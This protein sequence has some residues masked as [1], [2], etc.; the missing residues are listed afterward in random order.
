[1]TEDKRQMQIALQTELTQGLSEAEA[2]ARSERYGENRLSE[3]KKK[4]LVRRFFEQF[5]DMMIL[6]LLVAAAVSF[7]LAFADGG[8]DLIELLEPVLILG[9]VIADA[10]LGVIQ[11]SKAEKALEALKKLSAPTARVLRE[12]KVRVIPASLLVPG[13]VVLLEAGDFVPAD[14]RLAESHSLKCEESALTGESVAAEK[15]AAAEVPENAPVAE[16][17]NEVFAGTYVTYG[18]GKA[19]VTRTGMATETGKIAA[20]LSGEKQEATPLQKK[21]GKLGKY[22]GVAALA[23][24]AVIFVMGMISGQEPMELFMTAVSLAVAAIP[25]GL[26]AVVTVVLAVGVQRMAKKNAV[27]RR[28]PAVETLGSA[29]VICS[30][31]TGTLTQ[32]RMTLVRAYADG[33]AEEV[34][35]AHNGEQVRRLLLLGTLCSEGSVER[36][37]DGETHIGDPTETSIVSAALKNGMEKAELYLRYPRTATLPFDSDRKLM[38]SVHRMDGRRVAIVK[39]AFDSVAARAVSG[40]LKTAEEKCAEMSASALRVLAIAAKEL[41]EDE[42]PSEWETGLTFL[43]L[44]GMIDPPRPEAREAV[45][46]CREAGIRPVMITGDSLVTASAIAKDLGILREGDEALLGTQVDTMSENELVERVDKVSVYA[47]VSPENKIAIVKAWQARGEIVAMTGD[48]VNDAPALKAADIG[49]AMGVTGTDVAKGAADMTLSDDNFSTIVDA[50]EEGRG[51][52][53]NIRKVV[54]FLLGTNIGELLLVFAAML[55]WGASPLISIQ[56]LWIN[57]VSDGFP[58][59]ALGLDG[60]DASLM[61]RAPKR[62]AEGIFSG[63]YLFEI[64]FQGFVFGGI[65]FAAYYIGCMT[66]GT[67]SAGQTLAFLVFAVAKLLQAYHARTERSIFL[68]NPFSNR[69]LNCAIALSLV[70]TFAVALIPGVRAVFGF[71]ILSAQ[72]YLAGLGLVF[73]PTVTTECYK[74]IRLAVRAKRKS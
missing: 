52:Y 42:P 9:V 57:L 61:K 7:G 3:G 19:I 73:V 55:A 58:A 38:T 18:T 8:A 25:E 70:L 59:I 37:E 60:S 48:G 35:G 51:I 12:G 21:L 56:L 69:Y 43:G 68:S 45:A 24:C 39:G 30:D 44:L 16:R 26:P 5:K 22:L 32:N 47:R 1:M 6:I 62:R 27:I 53:A 34:I 72:A 67:E 65:S 74:A 54:G 41:K 36:T 28:L 40:D 31:K 23:V 10:V 64:L 17:A 50:V 33:G 2:A 11:E 4:S 71:S 15:D 66:G 13:D 46:R 49:C 14:G 20:L 29:S 63:G